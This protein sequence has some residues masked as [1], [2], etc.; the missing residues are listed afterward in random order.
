MDICIAWVRS[1]VLRIE[2]LDFLFI[3]CLLSHSH[4]LSSLSFMLLSQ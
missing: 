2:K 3:L 4:N 1:G